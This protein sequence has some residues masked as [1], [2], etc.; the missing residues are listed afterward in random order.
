M[1]NEL[2]AEMAEE[3]VQKRPGRRNLR[4]RKRS[5]S[6]FPSP[7]RIGPR[8]LTKTVALRMIFVK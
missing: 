8:A 6:T 2:L 5:R 7:P 4:C 1:Y 3:R